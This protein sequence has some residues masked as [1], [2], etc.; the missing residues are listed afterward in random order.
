MAP[1]EALD[2]AIV[3]QTIAQL[4][5]DG[6]TQRYL[7]KRSGER[8]L[9]GHLGVASARVVPDDAGSEEIDHSMRRILVVQRCL[10]EIAGAHSLM[11]WNDEPGRTSDDVLELLRRGRER[12]VATIPTTTEEE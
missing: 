2:V 7:T 8:C 11:E 10:R 6:W 3:D 1:L 5:Q 4:E 12:L 9:V